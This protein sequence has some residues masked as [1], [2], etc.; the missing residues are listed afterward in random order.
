MIPTTILLQAL[1][2]AAGGVFSFGSILLVLL[3]LSSQKG[4][5]KALAYYAGYFG[6]YSLVGLLAMQARAFL[7]RSSGDASSGSHKG[8]WLSIAFGCLLL[9]FARQQL[10][11]PKDAPTQLPKF[12][13]TLDQLSASRVFALGLMISFV[14][15]KNLT[16]YLSAITVVIESGSPAVQI[17]P[18]IV[19][20]AFV[21]CLAVLSPIVLF[22]VFA[23]RAL[24]WLASLKRWL[25]ANQRTVTI[26]MMSLFGTAL[27]LRGVY[28][29]IQAR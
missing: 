10:R 26:T 27:L 21:F 2:I 1:A 25:E 6:G 9:Y 13:D 19:V 16:I 18:S 15:F 8:L 20:V 3:L 12:F 14:N 5:K 4:L 23:K 28:G 22:A 29:L 7:Q 11:T 24:P 17:A